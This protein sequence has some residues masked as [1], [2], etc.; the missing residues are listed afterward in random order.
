[1]RS[2]ML[3][4]VGQSGS[5]FRLL[6]AFSASK[7]E[8]T[9]RQQRNA[10][11]HCSSRETAWGRKLTQQLVEIT[12]QA[13][14]GQHPATLICLAELAWMPLSR[15]TMLQKLVIVHEKVLRTGYLTAVLWVTPLAHTSHG[16]LMF[17]FRCRLQACRFQLWV[18]L[19]DWE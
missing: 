11:I 5:S 2:Q 1:M 16:R 4:I 14:V 12:G 13:E 7:K 10:T 17:F 18:C 9:N 6:V 8:R 15:M 3:R 19:I